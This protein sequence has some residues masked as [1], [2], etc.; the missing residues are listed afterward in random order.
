M[1]NKE[2]AEL[3]AQFYGQITD[4]LGAMAEVGAC[5]PTVDG[6]LFHVGEEFVEVSVTVK[7][8]TKFVLETARAKYAEKM[9][10][11]AERAEKARAAAEEIERKA[12]EK[13][14]KAAAKQKKQEEDK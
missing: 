9:R 13:A 3:R 12:R 5:E 8:K 11:A 10:R 6:L 4:S 2:K 7:D 14:E 1:T